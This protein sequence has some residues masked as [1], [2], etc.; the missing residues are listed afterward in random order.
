MRYGVCTWTFGHEPLTSIA[1][2][3]ASLGLDGVELAGDLSLDPR[4]ARQLLA[5]HGLAV[6]S[7]TPDNVDI[8]H[9]DPGV[10]RPSLDYYLRLVDWAAELGAPLVTGHGAVGR[11][12]AVTGYAEERQLYL[13]AVGQIAARA[14]AVGLR[15]ALEL[16][17]RY[18]AHLLNT[19]EEGL[20]FLAGLRADNV[21]LLV[22]AYHANLEEPNL[23]LAIW[24]ASDRLFLFHA[25]DSNRQAVGRGHTDFIALTR[26]LKA[27]GYAGDVIFECVPQ[28]PDP[29]TPNKGPGSLAT[30]EVYLGESL[31]LMKSYWQAAGSRL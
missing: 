6:L 4:Q 16:L 3:V 30:L 9:P 2:R 7:I 18:E 25:A 15:V 8:C 5:D 31:A 17:N 11:V 28:G 22:D 21:G 23:P 24:R 10:R 20:G 1:R 19:V 12:R 29:F 27:V 26:A 14:R 13:E